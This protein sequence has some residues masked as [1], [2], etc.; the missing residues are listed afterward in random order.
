[1]RG[2]TRSLPHRNLILRNQHDNAETQEQGTATM[3]AITGA[4][5]A[6]PLAHPQPSRATRL[7]VG[8]TG[9]A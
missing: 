5:D 8:R 7:S 4:K 2:R 3:R 9:M 1:M 6:E